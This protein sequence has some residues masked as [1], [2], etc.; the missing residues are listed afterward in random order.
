MKSGRILL[1]LLLILLLLIS[2]CQDQADKK[3]EKS[4]Y[5][6]VSNLI[7]ERNRSRQEGPKSTSVKKYEPPKSI[8]DKKNHSS[9]SKD[10]DLAS[11]ILYEQKVKIV[12]SE[13]GKT[14]ARGVA[15]INKKGQIVKITIA[16]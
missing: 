9:K 3:N 5:S 13:S 11:I 10:N 15:Y 1:F 14:L 16:K 4:D 2:A 8:P 7:A 6:Y 12:G